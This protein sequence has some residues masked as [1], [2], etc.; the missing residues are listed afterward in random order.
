MLR[1]HSFTVAARF[2][3]VRFSVI[4]SMRLMYAFGLVVW[5]GESRGGLYDSVWNRIHSLLVKIKGAPF[6][7]NRYREVNT[8][9]VFSCRPAARF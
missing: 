1:Y 2:S 6:A 5:F 9:E 8:N 4:R 7:S 3:A